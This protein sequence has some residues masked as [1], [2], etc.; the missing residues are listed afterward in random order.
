MRLCVLRVACECFSTVLASAR[1]AAPLFSPALK[2]LLIIFKQF[3]NSLLQEPSFGMGTLDILNSTHAKWAWNR[4]QQ[5]L[6][7]PSDEVT[8]VRRPDKCA[9]ARSARA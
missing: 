4:N 5:P 6:G 3:E 2:K 7:Q 8:L 9:N 1:A